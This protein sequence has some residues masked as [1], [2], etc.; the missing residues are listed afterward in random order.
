MTSNSPDLNSWYDQL[1]RTY[2]DEEVVK[3]I[4]NRMRSETAKETARS[5]GLI[6]ASELRR[7]R[8]YV[9]AE[10]VLLDLAQGNPA[11]PYPLIALAVQKLY[12]EER[13]EEALHIAERAV[14]T[15]RASGIFRRNA[16]GV[17]ARIAKKLN[18]YELLPDILREIMTIKFTESR[19]DVGIERDLIERLPAGA[20]DQALLQQY[21]EFCR[22]AASLT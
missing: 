7:Q 5:L 11:E 8:R 14:E 20:V 1:Q 3:E 4:T 13:P 16:L 9:Q 12:D 18:K 10:N 22:R 17:K 6:L 15:A 21:D 19:V 2:S